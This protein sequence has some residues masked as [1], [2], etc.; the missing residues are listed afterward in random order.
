M[1]I[2]CVKFLPAIDLGLVVGMSPESVAIFARVEIE[3][4]IAQVWLGE[5]W[6]STDVGMVIFLLLGH[7]GRK[8][9]GKSSGWLWVYNVS[10]K[11]LLGI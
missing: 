8:L 2:P 11:R 3:V 5:A 1:C 4:L 10:G 7:L 9:V 6:S